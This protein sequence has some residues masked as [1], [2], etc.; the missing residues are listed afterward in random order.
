M[1]SMGTIV[2]A[3]HPEQVIFT[4]LTD[5][6]GGFLGVTAH[7]TR[8]ANGNGFPHCAEGKDRSIDEMGGI[9]VAYALNRLMADHAPPGFTAAQERVGLLN[10]A[11]IGCRNNFC[12]PQTCDF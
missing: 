6:T 4:R 3:A 2:A 5:L 7:E 10:A 1:I 8:H 9:G 11:R 12:V